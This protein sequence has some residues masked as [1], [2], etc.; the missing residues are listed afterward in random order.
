MIAFTRNGEVDRGICLT[1]RYNFQVIL[2][3]HIVA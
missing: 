1:I 2:N 3:F